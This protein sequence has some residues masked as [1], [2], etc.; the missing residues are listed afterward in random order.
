MPHI[1]R[2]A[3][4]A[5]ASQALDQKLIAAGLKHTPTA[6]ELARDIL[7]ER[8]AQAT[9]SQIDNLIGTSAQRAVANSYFGGAAR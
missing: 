9:Q 4:L 2:T 7:N 8:K 1:S 6:N 3:G 5:L